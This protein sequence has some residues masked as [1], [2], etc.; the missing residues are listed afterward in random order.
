MAET[1]RLTVPGI[2]CEGCARAV[3]AA[4][5]PV[6]GVEQ[7][8]VDVTEKQVQVKHSGAEQSDIRRALEQ[9]GYPAS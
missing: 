3:K 7:V 2:S 5:T 9:A 1:L 8:D 4:L 6:S